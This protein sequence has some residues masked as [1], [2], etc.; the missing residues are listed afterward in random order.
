MLAGDVAIEPDHV[1]QTAAITPEARLWMACLIYLIDDAKKGWLSNFEASTP[2]AE[3]TWEAWADLIDAGP[4]TRHVCELT[5]HE[6]TAISRKFIRWCNANPPGSI[7][8]RKGGRG[9][10]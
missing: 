9:A 10:R 4:Q 5:G 2:P 7:L 6:P 8:S 3:I 1:E